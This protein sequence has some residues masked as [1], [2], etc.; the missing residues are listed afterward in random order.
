MTLTFSNLDWD[1]LWD[2]APK[3][4][5][6]H[7]LDDFETLSV[8]PASLGQGYTRSLEVCPGVWLDVSDQKFHQ[9]WRIQV[10]AHDHLVQYMVYL[11]GFVPPTEMYPTL[12]GAASGAWIAYP[13]MY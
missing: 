11:S 7:V 1:E 4:A 12:G 5:H 6:P 9:D 10:P 13:V 8:V 2:Q 3:P